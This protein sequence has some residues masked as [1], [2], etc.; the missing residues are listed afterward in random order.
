M[1]IDLWNTPYVYLQLCVINICFTFLISVVYEDEAVY[2]GEEEEAMKVEYKPERNIKDNYK[3]QT[4]WN[5]PEVIHKQDEN[6]VVQT[7]GTI[8]AES[9]S[10]SEVLEQEVA[11]CQE[12]QTAFEEVLST[13]DSQPSRNHGTERDP[14]SPID[15]VLV[16][17]TDTSGNVSGIDY[18]FSK[19]SSNENRHDT[20]IRGKES[21]I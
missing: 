14:Y 9:N 7:G 20:K 15:V 13:E 6:N 19:D 4:L 12:G 3:E 2:D 5:P 17:A 16:P 10:G 1:T 11:D 21:K 8:S 18:E